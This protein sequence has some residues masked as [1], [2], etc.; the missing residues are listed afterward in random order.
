MLSQ[1][2]IFPQIHLFSAVG[3]NPL[4]PSRPLWW[5][6]VPGPFRLFFV[7]DYLK[8]SAPAGRRG[9]RTALK[10]WYFVQGLTSRMGD[11]V[12]RFIAYS[13]LQLPGS[14]VTHNVV[15]SKPVDDVRSLMDNW[16]STAIKGLYSYIPVSTGEDTSI[17]EG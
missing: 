7:Q 5:E 16:R 11:A 3:C 6:T 13:T 12:W 14:S 8:A 1:S 4:S 15:D 10:T 9:V 2:S 17:S